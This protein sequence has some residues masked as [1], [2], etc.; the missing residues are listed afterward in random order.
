MSIE[1]T[2]KLLVNSLVEGGCHNRV[3]TS[4][5]IVCPYVVFYEIS[6][7]PETGVSV[8]YLG[9]TKFVFQVDV[10]ARSPEQAKGLAV[11][12]IRSAISGSTVLQGR[13]SFQHAGEYSELDK[14]FQY[15][16][17]YEFWTA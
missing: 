11:G 5:P 17:E 3:N 8:D 10:F 13:M 14:T 15:I 16:T 4:S 12:S 7:V 9:I 6:G 2:L 1:S